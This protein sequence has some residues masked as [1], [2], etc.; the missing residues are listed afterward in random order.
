MKRANE[1]IIQLRD[2]A[3][4]TKD[5]FK[6]KALMS[7][8]D[9]IETQ[10]SSDDEIDAEVI[11]SFDGIGKGIIR[12][13]STPAKESSS[14][15]SELSDIMG[16][17]PSTIKKANS[18]GV[19][20]ILDAIKLGKHNW[21]NQQWIGLIHS[22]DL[23]LRIPREEVK[24][25]GFS[26]ISKIQKWVSLYELVGSYRRNKP[27]SGDVDILVFINNINNINNIITSLC[28]LI[29]APEIVSS[30]NEKITLIWNPYG[31]YRHIDIFIC[32]SE[33]QWI[34]M[35][36]HTTGSVEHN[37]ELR[38]LAIARGWKL[39]QHGLTRVNEEFI[40][41][42]TEESLYKLLEIPYQH[43]HNR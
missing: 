25:I 6:K 20:T 8:A 41:L 19:Y 14:S 22:D 34:P 40:S 15:P 1:F 7:A 42:D 29:P 43:P 3:N 38:R 17:G 4:K 10:F 12:R 37:T 39:S 5:R 36:L 28:T 16:F 2:E 21:N 11:K 30:G 27:D 13:L 24:L 31:V 18:D 26:I 33:K 32:S 35:L 9:V 23:K